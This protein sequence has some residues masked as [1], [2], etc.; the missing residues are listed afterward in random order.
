MAEA[1]V[2]AR[3]EGRI[4]EPR[5]VL[6]R[7]ELHRLPMLRLDEL[8]RDVPPEDGDTLSGMLVEVAGGNDAAIA[9]NGLVRLQWV[10][11]EE[12]PERLDLVAKHRGAVVRRS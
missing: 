9:R 3:K 8:R 2:S 1:L 5:R 11:A 12:E 7:D 10:N 4:H 6:E